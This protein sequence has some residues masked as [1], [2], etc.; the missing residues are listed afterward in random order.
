MS[1]NLVIVESPAKGKT[2]A[3]FLGKDYQ[4]EASYGHIRDL[5]KSGM[6]IDIEHGFTPTYEISPDKKK[7]ITELKKLAKAADTVWLASDEDREGEAISWHLCQALGLDPKTTNRIVF[8]EITKTAIEKAIAGPRHVDQHLVDAQQARRVLD[9]IVGYEL[10]PV[11]WKKVQPKLSAGRVQSVAV[12]VIVEREHEIEAFTANSSYKV[13]AE[14]K[15]DKSTLKAEL[16]QRFKTE[17][18]ARAF[19]NDVIPANFTVADIETK[20][21]KRSP[22]APFTTSTLQQEASRKLSFSVK[23]TMVVAQRLYE[24]GKITY[25]RTDSVHLS[26]LAI[27]GS[28]EMIT[29][30]FGAQYLQTRQFT[31]KSA[32][33]QEAHEAIRP[34]NFGDSTITG[35]R[36]EERLYELIWK[37][38]VAS[39][40]ADARLER[41]TAHI[42][43]STRP[44]LLTA[45]GEVVLFDGFLK[46]YLAQD[47]DEDTEEEGILPPITAGQ[48]LPLNTMLAAQLYDR[49]KPRYTE[50]SLV[51]RLEE[52]GIGRPSTY[53]P[54]ISTIQDRGYIEK[55]DLEGKERQL[56]RLTLAAGT[57]TEET[58]TEMA[59]ADRNKLFPTSIGMVVNDFLVKNFPEVVDYQFTKKVEEEFD[60]IADGKQ[61]WNAM[62]AK[63]YERFHPTVVEVGGEKGERPEDRELGA[64]PAS[65]KRII[66]RLG[67]FGPMVQ[68]GD[69]DDED[70]KFAPLPPGTMIHNVTLEQA[71][72]MFRLP[73][74][75]GETPDGKEIT[76][77]AGRFGPYIKWNGLYASIKPDDPFTIT[78]ERALELVID[79]ESAEAN[80]YIKQFEGTTV[81]IVNGR[82][83]P[84]ITDGKKNAKIPKDT[85]PE[86]IDLKQAQALIDAAPAK[87]KRHRIVKS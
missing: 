17:A 6:S 11:L 27:S 41:T 49:P 2:I 52:M 48:V 30:D 5:P 54:T 51:K 23:Q 46:L 44:E 53:A 80:K 72:E 10:S 35:E 47:T 67:R 86:S 68:M 28:S 79:K 1:K 84:Y 60:Q 58:A 50:A 57:I 36:N 70:K 31:T 64:D 81:A 77:N 63:F 3:K 45:K 56:H 73:R 61:A 75:L 38:T 19:L 71:L 18:E 82:Y 16:P 37:R 15:V 32:G 13:T 83:G 33:A 40:M 69:R 20:P 76:T 7:R 65:G 87:S 39:Q 74:V 24:A 4:V 34:T 55:G 21:A 29:R 43:I 14:F 66:A 8:H 62:I 22:A 25:M 26:D 78:L 9:R 42:N 12:R 59:G 85:A